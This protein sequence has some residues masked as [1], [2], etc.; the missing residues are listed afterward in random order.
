LTANLLGL[1]LAYAL[2]LPVS[3]AIILVAAALV[4]ATRVRNYDL[5]NLLSG[6]GHG[7]APR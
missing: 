4:L 5:W 6:A 2:D 7:P 1:G 3:P